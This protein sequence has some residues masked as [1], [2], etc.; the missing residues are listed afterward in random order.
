MAEDNE[1]FSDI[2]S[3]GEEEGSGEDDVDPYTNEYTRANTA[4]ITGEDRRYTPIFTSFI[5]TRIICTRAEQID[6]GSPVG[7]NPQEKGLTKSL[8]IAAEELRQGKCPL[9]VGMMSNNGKKVEH[10]H[11]NELQPTERKIEGDIEPPIDR[12]KNMQSVEDLLGECIAWPKLR[13]HRRDKL[14]ELSVNPTP[15][16]RPTTVPKKA[17]PKKVVVLSSSSSD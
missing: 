16:T 12:V 13:E 5:L 15:S 9:Y 11:V 10:W 8:D 2:D 7:I 17:T 4:V 1:D 6:A 3:D 14:P